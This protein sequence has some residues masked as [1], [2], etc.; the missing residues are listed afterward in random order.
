FGG[1]FKIIETIK[2]RIRDEIGEYVTVS[3][4]LSYNKLLAKLGSGMNK[5]NG[6]TVISEKNLEEIYSKVELTD[7]C[8][9]GEKIKLFNNLKKFYLVLIFPNFSISTSEIYKNFNLRLTKCRKKNY[10]YIFDKLKFNVTDYL[11]NDLE[12]VTENKY[13]D[14]VKIKDTLLSL[15]AEGA[16]MSGS[17]STVF[18][19]FS[20]LK[21]A[22]NVY[23]SLSKKDNWQLFLAHLLI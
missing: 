12:T 21:E 10:N 7:F 2:K 14:I 18:G 20:S 16:L 11:C 22:K 23:E 8:G 19:L 5:P 1:R 3:V 15:G 6:L 17:G 9:I 4:G 13:P